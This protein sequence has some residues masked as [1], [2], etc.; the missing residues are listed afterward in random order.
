ML[1]IVQ[2][3]RP[4]DFFSAKQ[5]KRLRELMD[6]FHGAIAQGTPLDPILQTELDALVEA[7]LVANIR[8]SQRLLLQ[9]DRGL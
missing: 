3:F 8:R 7:E 2:R 5:Q 6:L 4:D 1:V 9:R